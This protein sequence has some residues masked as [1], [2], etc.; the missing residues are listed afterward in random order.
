MTRLLIALTVAGFLLATNVAE[1]RVVCY[2]A[3]WTIYRP[4]NGKFQATD[5]DP[6]LCTHIYYAFVGLRDDGY[7]SVLDDW[8]LTG[9]GKSSKK[10]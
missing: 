8:E 10:K 9:L 4:D 5:V 2:F 3:S 1:G 6:N 7:V